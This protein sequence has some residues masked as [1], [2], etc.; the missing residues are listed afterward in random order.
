M[1]DA[2]SSRVGALA[3]PR[4]DYGFP[5]TPM[6]GVPPGSYWL[7]PAVRG[8]R[9]GWFVKSVS[10]RGRDLLEHPIDVG[11][12]PITDLVVGVTNRPVEVTGIVTRRNRLSVQDITVIAFPARP[13]LRRL[14]AGPMR[15]LATAPV[16]REGRYVIHGLPPG[17]YH[18]AA[19]LEAEMDGWPDASFLDDR[20]PTSTRVVVR[21]GQRHIVHLAVTR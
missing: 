17:E 15:R 18:V 4:L 6:R 12:E 9:G 21:D 1:L 8:D 2:V 20:A 13:E 3:A 5:R 10:R 19:V 14:S 7:W 11:T 16:D